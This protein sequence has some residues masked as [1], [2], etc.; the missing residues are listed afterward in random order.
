MCR[1]LKL[2]SFL[3]AGISHSSCT[4]VDVRFKENSITSN[5]I[6]YFYKSY[7]C[8][9]SEYKA[10]LALLLFHSYQ[11]LRRSS[12]FKLMPFYSTFLC[13]IKHVSRLSAQSVSTHAVWLSRSHCM[14]GPSNHYK[15]APKAKR[16]TSNYCFVQ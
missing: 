12:V 14:Y 2:T 7:Q 10:S 4:E 6:Y 15:A 8:K 1:Q 16:V 13:S 11:G 3:N 5:D 9:P